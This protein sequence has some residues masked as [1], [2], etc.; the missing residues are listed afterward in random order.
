MGRSIGQ[1]DDH[2][3]KNDD[4]K[5]LVQNEQSVLDA[6]VQIVPDHDPTD[7]QHDEDREGY[8]PVQSRAGPR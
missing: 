4:T 2:Q 1:P 6:A 3:Q 8:D 5:V 7:R